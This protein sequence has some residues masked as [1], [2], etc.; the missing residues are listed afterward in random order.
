MNLEDEL[1]KAGAF[2]AAEIDRLKRKEAKERYKEAQLKTQLE[3]ADN[4]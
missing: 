4:G 1:A 3:G 2:C